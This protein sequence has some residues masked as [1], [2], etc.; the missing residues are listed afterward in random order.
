MSKLGRNQNQATMGKVR[1]LIDQI[2]ELNGKKLDFENAEE[3]AEVFN[4]YWPV[5]KKVLT[6]IKDMKITRK[7]A[8]GKINQ[9]II[10]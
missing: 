6:T 10:I 5:L 9:A 8:D 1:L 2:E 4:N 3:F 7:K